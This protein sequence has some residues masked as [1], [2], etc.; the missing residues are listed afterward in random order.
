MSRTAGL[1]MAQA[2]RTTKRAWRGESPD[3]RQQQRRERLMDAALEAFAQHGIAKTTMRDI[4]TEAR[5]TERY[6]YESF[7]NTEHAF[8]EVFA[9]LR[10]ALVARVMADMAQSPRKIEDLARSGLRAFYT[11]IQE[12]PRR[13]RVMLLDG[14]SAKRSNF[15][16]SR[17][18]F[19][20]YVVLM[21][22]LAA[23]LY[24]SVHPELNMEF[25]AWGMVGVAVQV[26]TVWAAQDMVTPVDEVLEYN[27][28]AWRGL[29]TW[30]D[31]RAAAAPSAIPAI[32]ASPA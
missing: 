26:G 15:E 31:A 29:Q 13:A 12:D 18:L 19:T 21:D 28:Y 3:E 9:R 2:P 10:Q 17:E 23:T 1:D 27:L 24:P 6:F 30:F 32:P 8:D 25:V 22:Q 16:R 7:R 14:A 20:D 5:L 4:C 11:F